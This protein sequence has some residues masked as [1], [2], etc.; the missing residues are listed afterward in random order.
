MTDVT[1]RR[2]RLASPATALIF[3]S[4]V[5]AHAAAVGL[6]H[7]TMDANPGAGLQGSSLSRGLR[8]PASGQTSSKRCDP[9]LGRRH[10][11]G[12][13]AHRSEPDINQ[14]TIDYIGH[15]VPSTAGRPSCPCQ[16]S[17]WPS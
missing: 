9:L 2:L 16:L 3:G 15:Y 11:P 5:L 7:M 8:P 4:L 6:A 12:L 17:D 13:R 10:G 14:Q 1:G